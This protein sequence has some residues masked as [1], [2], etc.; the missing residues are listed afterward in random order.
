MAVLREQKFMISEPD[1]FKITI[2]QERTWISN[3]SN[4]EG[5]LL[6]V[7]E[8]QEVI[9]G[10]LN[11]EPGNRRRIKHVG[12]LGMNVHHEW[13]N[14]GVGRKLLEVLIEW[15]HKHPMIEKIALNVLAN[16]VDA[17]RLYQKCGFLIEGIRPG[18]IKL[19]ETEYVDD[20]LMY[21][22]V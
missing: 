9:I 11:F 6:L 7:A 1:E 21:R 16:N 3:Y 22:F 2:D 4:T 8:V 14:L 19:S 15:A 13:R 20:I 10:I 12:I 18:E 17:V 5:K